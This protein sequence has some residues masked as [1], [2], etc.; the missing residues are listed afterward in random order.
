[1]SEHIE[2]TTEDSFRLLTVEAMNK[3]TRIVVISIFIPERMW[4][5]YH[6]L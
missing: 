2:P 4:Y 1:M 5:F 3:V 6:Q